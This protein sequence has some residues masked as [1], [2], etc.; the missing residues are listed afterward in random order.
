MHLKTFNSCRKKKVLNESS[1]FPRI[2]KTL[3]HSSKIMK[4]IDPPN[5]FYVIRNNKIS[6]SK[7]KLPELIKCKQNT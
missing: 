6:V 2:I 7:Q 3:I 4:A 5:N 1:N